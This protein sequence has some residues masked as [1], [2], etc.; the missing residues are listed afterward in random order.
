MLKIMPLAGEECA[1]LWSGRRLGGVRDVGATED[2]FNTSRDF[3]NNNAV[4]QQPVTLELQRWGRGET[5][6]E[7]SSR[8]GGTRSCGLLESPMDVLSLAPLPA[9]CTPVAHLRGRD[10]A[11]RIHRNVSNT[12]EWRPRDERR[13]C[14]LLMELG[15][16]CPHVHIPS[17]GHGHHW[18][19][20]VGLPTASG[21]SWTCGQHW[22]WVRGH[23]C[24]FPS[25]GLYDCSLLAYSLCVLCAESCV[26]R[27]QA[28]NT[29]WDTQAVVLLKDWPLV[30]LGA[31]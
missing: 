3:A 30:A 25:A 14:F 11:L 5:R 10:A 12:I 15:Q 6:S 27:R 4:K 23:C 16:T 31:T 22:V 26:W 29:T 24:V 19:S 9:S 28:V 8:S 21:L 7:P 18:L 1:R 2:V 17:A 13:E 20:G